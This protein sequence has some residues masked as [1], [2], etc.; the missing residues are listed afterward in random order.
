[1][2]Q[3]MYTYHGETVVHDVAEEGA[4][5]TF[6]TVAC[7]IACN[8]FKGGY[9][10]QPSSCVQCCT[11]CPGLNKAETELQLYTLQHYFHFFFS[12]F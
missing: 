3:M 4:D 7:N 8:N 2:L 9:M 1:M 11:V 6:A 5:S 12:F 10:V